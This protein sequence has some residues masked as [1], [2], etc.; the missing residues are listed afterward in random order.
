MPQNESYTSTLLLSLIYYLVPELDVSLLPRRGH[1]GRLLGMPQHAGDG[2][3]AAIHLEL[4]V[5]LARLPVVEEDASHAVARHEELAVRADVDPDR[6]PSRVVAAV[7]LLPVLAE[8]VRCR[9]DQDLVVGLESDVLGAGVQG[10][11]GYWVE[12]RLRDVFDRYLIIRLVCSRM[13]WQLRRIERTQYLLA[14][15]SSS[16]VCSCRQTLT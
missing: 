3:T 10:G 6:R 2:C 11:A 12:V 4:L 9:V 15:P 1:L 7:H 13:P 16:T 8:L 5:H 14:R